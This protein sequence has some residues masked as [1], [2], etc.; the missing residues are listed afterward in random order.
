M[1]D[2]SSP[3]SARTGKV[4]GSTGSTQPKIE[5][6]TLTV[7]DSI[8]SY[9]R[10][11]CPCVL[12]VVSLGACATSPEGSYWGADATVAPGWDRIGHAALTA[13]KDP[14]T[15][16]PAVGA[17]ALQ[18]GHLDDK[19]ADWANQ[20]TPVFGSR[21]TASDVSD[22]ARAT[23]V[24]LYVGTGLGAPAPSDDW[25]LTKA[26]GFAV[27]AAAIAT[28]A[29]LTEATKEITRRDRPTGQNKDSFPSGHVSSATVSARLTYETIRHY[30]L[31]PGARIATDVGLVGLTLTTGW[32]RVEAGEHRPADVLAGAALGNF[33]AVLATEAFLRPRFGASVGLHTAPYRNGMKL[34]VSISF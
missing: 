32:A 4:S 14:F 10:R 22:W 27:G 16:I 3:G 28:T 33:I 21:K 26:K 34:Q 31:S 23:S 5:V 13:A 30:D 7:V 9:A 18:I 25:V 11:Q 8:G 29:G 15:W 6:S 17:A 12:L 19:I 24:V 20:K 1:M 2:G